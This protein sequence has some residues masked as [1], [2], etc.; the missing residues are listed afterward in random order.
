MK[1]VILILLAV[2]LIS[3]KS[4]Q[5]QDTLEKKPSKPVYRGEDIGI[6][7]GQFKF[8]AEVVSIRREPGNN[9][10]KTFN[11]T[12]ALK[13]QQIYLTGSATRNVPNL[14]S[15]IAFA[16]KTPAGQLKRG[17]IIE[18]IATEMLCKDLSRSYFVLDEYVVVQ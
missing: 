15:V 17:N 16:L 13:I 5:A 1:Y 7:P 14:S 12:V 18:G 4:L 10:G 11:Q 8:K 3:C 9:C 6:A 2:S